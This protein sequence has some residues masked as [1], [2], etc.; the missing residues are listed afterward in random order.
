MDTCLELLTIIHLAAGSS[1]TPF[2]HAASAAHSPANLY[3]TP[4]SFFGITLVI[5]DTFLRLACYKA[6]GSLFTFDLCIRPEHRLV[7]TFPYNIVRHPAYLGSLCLTAGLTFTGL[8]SGSWILECGVPHTAVGYWV[9][10]L[11]GLVW[12]TFTAGVGWTRSIA[13]DEQMKKQ[14]PG[15]WEVYAKRVRYWFVPGLI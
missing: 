1:S 7:T 5:L 3:V 13:E 4:L 6:L 11:T 8:T 15:E 10:V 2:C 12:W 9:V 14:F